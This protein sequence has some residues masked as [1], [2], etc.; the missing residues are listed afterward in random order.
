MHHRRHEYS[1]QD[2]YLSATPME[3]LGS[4]LHLSI[5]RRP[6][7]SHR[8]LNKSCLSTHT[9]ANTHTHK[10]KF[11][12]GG[13]KK[14]KNNTKLCVGLEQCFKERIRCQQFDFWNS[15]SRRMCGTEGVCFQLNVLRITGVEY[16][17]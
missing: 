13:R 14:R 2:E 10:V 4:S 3:K 8:P 17:Q 7:E 11:R 15:V 16:L 6:G 9:H 1:Y 12:Q 5:I